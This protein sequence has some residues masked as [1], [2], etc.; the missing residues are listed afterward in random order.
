MRPVRGTLNHV[1]L[2]GYL[3]GDP[4]HRIVPSGASVASFSI[5][6]KRYGARNEGGQRGYE[7]DWTNV[8]AWDKL[9]ELCSSYLHKGSR[10]RISGTLQS[11]SWED[12]ESGQRRY[13]TV[14][15]ANSLM[16]LDVRAAESAVDAE[17]DDE[18]VFEEEA[19]GV[20]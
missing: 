20:E 6:T 17:S 15:R 2:I 18:A 3:G 9:A 13:R 7:T 5:A 1:E 8:E 10:V 14:V 4:D 12:K 11:R 19:E 16:F